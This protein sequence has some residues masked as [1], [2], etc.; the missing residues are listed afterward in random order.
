MKAYVSPPIAIGLTSLIFALAHFS[1]NQT[2]ALTLLGIIFGVLAAGTG[3]VS[4]FTV[5]SPVQ[6]NF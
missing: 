4:C 6:L 3:N 5:K 1:P 2:L